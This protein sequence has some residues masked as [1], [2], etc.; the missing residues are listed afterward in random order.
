MNKTRNNSLRAWLTA[1]CAA[2]FCLLGTQTAWGQSTGTTQGV[3]VGSTDVTT[4]NDAPVTNGDIKEATSGSPV[5]VTVTDKTG[6]TTPQVAKVTVVRYDQVKVT[7]ITVTSAGNVTEMNGNAQLQMSA[8]IVPTYADNKTVTW[9]VASAAGSSATATIDASTGLL[10]AGTVQGDVVVT[11][12][13]ADGSAV[14]DS[15]TITI[16]TIPLDET[17]TTITVA[18]ATYTGSALTPGVTV[19]YGTTDLVEGQDYTLGSWDNNT[20]AGTA[21]VTITGTGAYSGSIVKNFTIARASW[22]GS[23]SLSYTILS[24]SYKNVHF[25]YN[26]E[27][28]GN[29]SKWERCY[30]TNDYWND[31]NPNWAVPDG[32]GTNTSSDETFT[33]AVQKV[34]YRV[35]IGPDTQNHKQTVITSAILNTP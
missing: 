7:G 14:S 15:K 6:G 12:M 26:G 35:T 21:S 23:I 13:A 19:K 34:Q 24:N 8:T 3:K 22:S 2:A 30:S 25:Q 5:K 32:S 18:A 11:A 29:I 1:L 16:T 10:R 33:R 17:S 27:G 31:L 28:S 9:S 20:N 4:V